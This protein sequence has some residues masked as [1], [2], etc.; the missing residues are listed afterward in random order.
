MLGMGAGGVGA[1]VG[2]VVGISL[3]IYVAVVDLRKRD[4]G[5]R[6]RAEYKGSLVLVP[7]ILAAIGTAVGIG[8]ARVF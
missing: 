4:A 7:L 1:I 3:S 2:L 8:I 6:V 5:V